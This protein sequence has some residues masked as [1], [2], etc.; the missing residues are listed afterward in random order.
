MKQINKEVKNRENERFY[1]EIIPSEV[2][3]ALISSPLSLTFRF[4]IL[5]KLEKSM[6]EAKNSRGNI[7]T[8]YGYFE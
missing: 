1:K 8:T 3:F 5:Y 7:N 2:K 6:V 4:L